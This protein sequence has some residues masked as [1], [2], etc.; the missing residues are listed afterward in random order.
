MGHTRAESSGK[1]YGSQAMEYGFE[2]T[3]EEMYAR[4]FCDTATGKPGSKL[5]TH[6][7]Q[8]DKRRS[9]DG[10]DKPKNAPYASFDCPECIQMA[11]LMLEEELKFYMQRN[12]FK[13]KDGAKGRSTGKQGA[14]AKS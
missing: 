7:K 9:A 8:E 1:A 3:E 5:S 14:N 4:L 13:R 6:S 12:T 10:K 11:N 2:L